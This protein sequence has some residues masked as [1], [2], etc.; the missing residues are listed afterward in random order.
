M[1]K[2]TIDTTQNVS[3]EYEIASLGDRIVA[4]LIDWL[5]LLGYYIAYLIILGIFGRSL[6]YG[7]GFVIIFLTLIVP[8]L[9]YPLLCETFMNGQ[10]FGKR[11]RKIKVIRM[12]GRQ[13]NF[14]NYLLRWLIG[15]IEIPFYGVIAIITIVINGKGQRLGDIAAGT[16]V[17]KLRNKQS[18]S[19][20]AFVNV[21]DAYIPVF[22]QASNLTDAEATTIREVLQLKNSENQYI[23]LVRLATKLK[24]Y[25]KIETTLDNE[26]FLKTLLK[27]FNKINGRL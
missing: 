27:D 6:F 14:G 5:I 4:T 11:A 1:D 20:T 16:A 17:V 19:S 13:P 10:S 26:S 18:I 2:I 24:E 9:L 3:I 23:I 7:G 21:E 22:P 15:M 8:M 25:L 12:D